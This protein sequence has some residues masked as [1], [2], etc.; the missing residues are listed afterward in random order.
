MR[1]CLLLFL[2][3]VCAAPLWSGIFPKPEMDF[4]F[5]YQ[6]ELSPAILPDT[7]EQIQCDDNQCLQSTPLG[8]YGLQKL[9]CSDKDC[10]SVAYQYAPYQ[11]LAIDFS[12]GIKR[13][14]NVFP[15]S[16]KLRGSFTVTV[17]DADLL[18]QPAASPRPLNALSRADGWLS[19]LI[20]LLT[21]A[22]AAFAYLAYTG[23]SYRVI[24]GVIAANLITIPLTWLVFGNFVTE[25]ALLWLF[26]LVFE[27]L[28]VWGFNR[29]HLSLR[30]AAALSVAVN[31]TS[32][33]IGTML[34][35]LI[36]PYLF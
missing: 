1:K 10:F 35:F 8:K 36:A 9:Y 22:L 15:S 19:L 23:K 2:L 12:D 13:K 6:T 34:S 27:A 5:V 32:Y 33:S 17:R 24:Y 16:R 20:I 3:A 11:Q 18:V 31:V 21:E 29:R 4:E 30:N 7:S 14:S 26:C 28:F 25:T